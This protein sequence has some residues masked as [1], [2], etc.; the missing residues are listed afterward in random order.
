M[1]Q[2]VTRLLA[3]SG[4]RLKEALKQEEMKTW[5][6][7]VAPPSP[8]LL[9]YVFP[10]QP[11]L[12]RSTWLSPLSECLSPWL[13]R[14]VYP[15]A[16]DFP[17]GSGLEKNGNTLLAFAEAPQQPVPHRWVCHLAQSALTQQPAQ[18]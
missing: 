5:N 4:G 16:C 7:F 17:L 1:S 18:A 9:P 15:R 14:V 8:S 10:S 2:S 13:P 6:Q 3:H 12:S 11:G